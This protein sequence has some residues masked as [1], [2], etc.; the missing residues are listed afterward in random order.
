[1]EDI[2]TKARQHV[3]SPLLMEQAAF[4]FVQC[5]KESFSPSLGDKM[6][7][8]CGKGGNGGDG[9]AAARTL[10]ADGYRNLFCVAFPTDNE[11]TKMERDA[12][13]AFPVT[14]LTPEQGLCALDDAS[15]LIDALFGTGLSR[16]LDGIGEQLVRKANA[17]RGVRCSIDVPSGLGESFPLEGATV[18][19]SSLTVTMGLEKEVFHY[20]PVR[21]FVG[22]V[23]VVNPSFPPSLLED[24]PSCSF[25][26]DGKS[27]PLEKLSPIAYKKT[28]GSLAVFA[29][30]LSFTGAAR[31]AVRS[32]FFS[33]SGLVTLFVDDDYY[34]IAS[35]ENLSAMVR[36]TE[37]GFDVG[38]FDAV[39]A[40]PGW[41]SGREALLRTLLE[42]GKPLVLD[43]DAITALCNLWKEGFRPSAPIVLTPH[44][45]ELDRLAMA[46]L[47]SKISNGGSDLFSSSLLSLSSLLHAVLVVK[48]S[49]NHIVSAGR[50]QVLPGDNPSL[51]V[52]GSGDVLSG[53]IASLLAERHALGDSA[54][55]GCC[56]HQRAGAIAR[57]KWGYYD[58]ESLIEAVGLAMKEREA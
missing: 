15:F 12:L 16:P 32:A 48:S 34:P 28:R 35:G 39:L 25:L 13:S 57:E 45:G 31:L 33:R 43:A 46:V 42:S 50:I 26:M 2:D 27:V 40:G 55:I 37:D 17:C 54:L 41:G 36:K 20:P 52:A 29:G 9:Y 51:G 38:K 4:R 1:M 3:P 44:L 21:E 22:N 23:V 56:V 18:F 14:F 11:Q 49:C 7:F 47:G 6:V 24:A 8:L 53:I 19:H 5:L 10:A 58:S 30:S